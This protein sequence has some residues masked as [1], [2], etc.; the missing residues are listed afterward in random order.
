MKPTNS[1]MANTAVRWGVIGTGRISDSVVPDMQAVDPNSV[2]AVW[3]RRAETAAD[4]AN[5]HGIAWHS[6]D[7][8]ELFAREDVDAVYIAT[9]IST[10]AD[11]VTL[12]LEA[13]KHVLVEKPMTSSAADSRK[14]FDLA[15]SRNRFVMEAMWMKF[16]PLHR[17]I[18]RLVGEG[19]LGEPRF[20]RASFGMPFPSTGS[21][22]SADLSG[23][24]VLDQGI[25]PVTLADWLLGP[26]L[27][28]SA[29]GLMRDGV[30]VTAQISLEHAGGRASQSACS[31]VEFRDPSGSVSGTKGWIEIP[32][33]FWAGDTAHVHAGSS[34]ALFHTPNELTRPREGN[35]Y[36][37]M[38]REVVQAI[39][40]GL[41]QHPHHDAAATLRVAKILDVVRAQIHDAGV[42]EPWRVP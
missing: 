16:N 30:D 34:E 4:F 8:S 40:G 14:L 23:S 20:V 3:G 17:E 25:Y 5:R 33:M 36:V 2:V 7:L 27:S 24:T 42:T 35:G 21:R 19:A 37:P 31:Q 32:A 15:R 22:W 12:A 10:H 28:V 41:L 18:A 13:D 29:T 1:E 6:D 9:P 38:I 26:T 11:L 39:G